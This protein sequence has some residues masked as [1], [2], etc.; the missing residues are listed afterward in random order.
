MLIYSLLFLKINFRIW[1]WVRVT[2][3]VG[4]R[5]RVKVWVGARF[6]G[7]LSILF[8]RNVIISLYL[9]NKKIQISFSYQFSY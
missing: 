4:V 3:K 6:M 7:R 8:L 2:I 9:Y 5:V 1:F